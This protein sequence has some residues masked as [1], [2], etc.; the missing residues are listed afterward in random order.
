VTRWSY[1]A[2][3]CVLWV[4]P[5]SEA[6]PPNPPLRP[7]DFWECRAG[8]EITIP[9]SR[10]EW[11]TSLNALH[12]LDPPT[13][14]RVQPGDWVAWIG[15][16]PKANARNPAYPTVLTLRRCQ[17]DQLAIREPADLEPEGAPCSPPR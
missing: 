2:G 15:V 8:D 13:V 11:P 10:A 7:F 16:R 12:D 9:A 17:A 1:A 5:D 14:W 4:R 3:D 6:E